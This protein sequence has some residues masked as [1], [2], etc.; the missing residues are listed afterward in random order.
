MAVIEF[1]KKF[2]KRE[3][4]SQ[5]QEKLACNFFCF[6]DSFR[7][8]LI[9]DRPSNCNLTTFVTFLRLKP[10]LFLHFSPYSIALSTL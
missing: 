1:I 9:E 4:L 8:N 5:G 10:P 3:K 6:S 2:K 7:R